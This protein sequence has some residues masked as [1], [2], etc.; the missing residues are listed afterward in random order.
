LAGLTDAPGAQHEATRV[1]ALRELL[2]RG[3]GKATQH[4]AG[5][6]DTAPMVISFEWAPA[7]P[8]AVAAEEATVGGTSTAAPL[9]LE[10]E[11][12]C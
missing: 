4:I 1:A 8:P 3:F 10:W 2:D 6:S 9:I 11:S 5:D 7:M 12:S